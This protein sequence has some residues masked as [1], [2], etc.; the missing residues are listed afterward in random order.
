[1]PFVITTEI[2]SS[3]PLSTR[4]IAGVYIGALRCEVCGCFVSAKA[5]IR[6]KCPKFET[7][8]DMMK[9]KTSQGILK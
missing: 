1:M 2:C 5:L 9:F 8:E 7:P 6:G 4:A 3:C